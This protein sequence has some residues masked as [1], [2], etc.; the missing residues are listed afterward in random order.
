MMCATPFEER[1]NA[2]VPPPRIHSMRSLSRSVKVT[3]FGS[4]GPRARARALL[5][6]K[7]GRRR[8]ARARADPKA[9]NGDLTESYSVSH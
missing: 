5:G 1:N 2:C 8:R 4:L 7:N 6:S 9:Q 3:I